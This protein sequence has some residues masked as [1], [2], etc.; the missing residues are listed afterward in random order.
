MK[1]A[2]KGK[3]LLLIV[4]VM[5]LVAAIGLY[6]AGYFKP[7][8]AGLIVESNPPASVYINGEQVGRTPYKAVQEPGEITL[9]LI[10][11]SFDVPLAPFEKKIVLTSG[12]ETVITQNFAESEDVSSG[13]I[14]SFERT[15]DNDSNVTILSQPDSAQVKLD[16]SIR[17]FT[18]H[19]ITEVV[20]GEHLLSITAPNYNELSVPIKVV[21][22]Y[23]LTAIVK[24]K[25]MEKVEEPEEVVAEETTEEYVEILSTPT[26]FLRVRN[27][28]DTTGDELTQVSPGER[29]LVVSKDEEEDWYEIEYEEDKT[30]WVSGEYVKSVDQLN[31]SE[32]SPTPT[33]TEN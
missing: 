26:N 29:Y 10:P 31:S 4:I 19:Q 8:G 11:D 25:P 7:T 16:E 15:A 1:P 12:V 18:P 17:G 33:E 27:E 32:L 6:I 22:G 28:P 30:G 13:A 24:L 14:L 21:K 3:K 5:S 2:N 23:T 20:E 9:S